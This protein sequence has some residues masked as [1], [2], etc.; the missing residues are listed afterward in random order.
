MQCGMICICW[1]KRFILI[2]LWCM[3]VFVMY[4]YS[5]VYSVIPHVKNHS[6]VKVRCLGLLNGVKYIEIVNTI[7]QT[8]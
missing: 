6:V 3:C 5:F 1:G 8:I 7:V 4:V 2:V